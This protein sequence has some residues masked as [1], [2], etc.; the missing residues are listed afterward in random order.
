[1]YNVK[2]LREKLVEK[3]TG[4]GINPK[5]KEN[6][7]YAA[8]ISEIDSLIGQMNMFEAAESVTVQEEQGRIL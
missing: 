3:V 8:A 2:E 4:L 6:P 5:F 1:M 7:A